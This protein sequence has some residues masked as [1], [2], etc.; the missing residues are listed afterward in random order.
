[1]LIKKGLNNNIANKPV[2]GPFQL[3]LEVF[4]IFKKPRPFSF[5]L[6]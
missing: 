5:Y 4:S 2:L 6:F 3:G 1:M